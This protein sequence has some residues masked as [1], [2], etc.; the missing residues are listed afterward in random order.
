MTP[1]KI[2]VLHLINSRG[3]YGAE[4]VIISLAAA[5]EGEKYSPSLALLQTKNYPTKEFIDAV[6]EKKADSYVIPCKRWIDIKA[7][8]QLREVIKENNIDIVHCHGMKGRLYGLLAGFG[9]KSK[10][11][12]TH[13]IWNRNNIRVYLFELFDAFYIRFFPKIIAVS[14]G[15]RQEL[16]DFFVPANKICI[17]INGINIDDFKRNDMHREEI[18]KKLNIDK[19]K[20]LIGTFGRIS[21]EKGQKHL[22]EAAKNIINKNKNVCFLIVGDGAEKEFIKKNAE[23]LG[24]YENM[25]FLDFQEDI[26]KYYSAIDILVIPSISDGT[27]M[28]LLE[29][30]S[31]GLPIVATEPGAGHVLRDGIDGLVV[32]PGQTEEL[33]KAVNRILTN[34]SEAELFAV[35]TLARVREKYSASIMAREHEKVYEE[36]LA[37]NE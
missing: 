25:I 28:V 9:M 1:R 6:E 4:R 7:V 23:H 29:A 11:I 15:V 10:L 2:K 36:L 12:T 19:D 8:L 18:R 33:A 27:P 14:P 31:A 20:I 34:K 32:R 35:N 16:L 22:I 5:A 3:L 30:M 13:H 26:N 24:V 21:P 17:I 37:G